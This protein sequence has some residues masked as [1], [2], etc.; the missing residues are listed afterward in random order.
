[1]AVLQMGSTIPK[2]QGCISSLRSVS[3]GI[4][5]LSF[6]V[7]SS[8]SSANL[9]CSPPATIIRM[10]GGPRTYPG[11]VSKWQWKRMQ[12]KKAKQLL[13][14]RLCRERQLYD[15]R[16]RAELKA[17]VGELEKPWE[18]V[19]RA[20]TLF[21]VDADEQVKALADRF[22]KPGGYDLWTEKD[23][24]QLFQTPDG[25][26]SARFFPKGVVHS[27]KHYT[28]IEESREPESGGYVEDDEVGEKG[29][30][31]NFA[32]LDEPKY[33]PRGKKN[34]MA[35]GRGNGN[36]RNFSSDLEYNSDEEYVDNDGNDP[37]RGVGLNRST[38]TGVSYRNRGKRFVRRSKVD[39]E[40]EEVFVNSRRREAKDKNG[41]NR[42]S[43]SGGQE[44][45]D[46]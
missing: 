24:P 9:V 19:R 44:N 39:R 29:F 5:N 34:S 20:P 15:M 42:I 36:P 37:D 30:S 32:V 6:W 13:K 1:M 7:R 31:D 41:I 4:E 14:A 46:I 11:G 8:S 45:M 23:G 25:L 21:S 33:G 18:A 27:V 38:R 10:G 26:P 40:Y 28:R 12:A 17:A 43:R 3:S 2:P 35:H 22:Q 16:K